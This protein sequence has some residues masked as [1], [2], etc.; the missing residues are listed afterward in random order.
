MLS[1]PIAYFLINGWG[2]RVSFVVFGAIGLVWAA[3]W[4]LWFRNSPSDHPAVN[5]AEL[6]WITQDASEASHVAT[7]WKQILSSRNLWAICAM[8]FGFGYGL[9]FYLTWMPTYLINQLGFTML[10]GGFFASLPF[11][12]AG[13][14]DISGGWLTDSLARTKGLRVAR[15]WLGAGRSSRRLPGWC[16]TKALGARGGSG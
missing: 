1:A 16:A 4:Q 2:W 8:Y 10:G 15:C 12:L 7:P 5:A 6:A 13:I 14:A 3:A 11:L 9:Y